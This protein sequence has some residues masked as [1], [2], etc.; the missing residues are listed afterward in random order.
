MGPLFTAGGGENGTATLENGL[1][2]PPKLTMPPTHST[3]RGLAV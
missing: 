3:P 2:V 1:A